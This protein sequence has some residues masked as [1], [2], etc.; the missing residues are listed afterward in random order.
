MYVAE[1]TVDMLTYEAHVDDFVAIQE[2]GRVIN[3]SAGYGTD[4]RR[5]GPGDWVSPYL[6]MSFGK[7][8]A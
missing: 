2:V 6:K 5:R 1:V 3:P 4:R 7:T 8:A